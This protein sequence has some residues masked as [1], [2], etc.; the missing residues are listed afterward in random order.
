MQYI[1]NIAKITDCHVFV[2]VANA[3]NEQ[4]NVLFP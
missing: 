1:F 2:T 3:L 4:Y